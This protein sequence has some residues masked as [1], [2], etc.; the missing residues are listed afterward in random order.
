MVCSGLEIS[1][2]AFVTA[3]VLA[4]SVERGYVNELDIGLL[5]SQPC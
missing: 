3:F 1:A 4:L 2:A 5:L